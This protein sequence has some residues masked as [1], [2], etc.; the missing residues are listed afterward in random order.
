MQ[1]DVETL[2]EYLNVIPA[3]RKEI[4][5]KLISVFKEYFPNMEGNMEYKMPTFNPICA[6]ASQKHYVSFYIYRHDL[7]D[8]YRKELGSLK[9]GKCCIRF[10]N[11]E[12][13]PETIIRQ[14]FTE[15][16]DKK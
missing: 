8:K 2:E 13:M 16:K 5:A 11:M 1:Y 7:I 9:V 12:Q 15:I 4:L 10:K 3:G 14:I 6:I